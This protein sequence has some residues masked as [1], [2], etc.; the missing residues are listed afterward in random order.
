MTP[1]D[2]VMP[3]AR[4]RAVSVAV[5]GG[6][7]ACASPSRLRAASTHLRD[8]T[9]LV[10]SRLPEPAVR[11]YCLGVRLGCG[12]FGEV[13]QGVESCSGAEV[14]VK[15]TAFSAQAMLE[16]WLQM[17]AAHRNV[18]PVWDIVPKPD[19]NTLMIVM[20]L[21]ANGSMEDMLGS[22]RTCSSLGARMPHS[23]VVGWIQQVL[24][25]LAHM[26]DVGIAH[27]DIKPA[28][29]MLTEQCEVQVADFGCAVQLGGARVACVEYAVGSPVFM[30][31]EAARLEVCRESDVW[32]VGILCFQLL[33][34][35]KTPYDA[36]L[37]SVG[38]V[39]GVCVTSVL[40]QHVASLQAV[41]GRCPGVPEELQELMTLCCTVD[42][43]C[44]PTASALLGAPC[45]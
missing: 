3:R 32:A 7:L 22:L 24:R 11:D 35:G 26:H 33:S 19:I 44:R 12:T 9:S 40:L 27:L 45:L 15:V 23:T 18:V 6:G 29:L 37:A 2:E 17:L 1:H 30:A 14:A 5:G 31:P 28:N 21:M 43:A 36:L 34:R 8:M 13:F 42:P 41:D 4:A 20:P 10:P 38:A 39:P 16:G 25:A